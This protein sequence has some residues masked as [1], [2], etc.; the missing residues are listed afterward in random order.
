M[1]IVQALTHCADCI[2]QLLTT[3]LL[4]AFFLKS[5]LKRFLNN[6]WSWPLLS[7]ASNSKK[8]SLLMSYTPLIILK[9][10]TK[11]LLARLC[12]GRR[13]LECQRRHLV[14]DLLSYWQPVEWLDEWTDICSTSMLTDDST[15]CS[16]LVAVCL[17]LWMAQTNKMALQ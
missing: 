10:S 15:G 2:F 9:V 16:A 14:G 12:T 6:F 5:S 3:L 17:R 8:Y 13:Y 11:S 7:P 4:N 1:F